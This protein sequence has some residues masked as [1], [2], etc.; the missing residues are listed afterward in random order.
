MHIWLKLGAQNIVFTTCGEH[1][2]QTTYSHTH[3]IFR[4]STHTHAP[5]HTHTH[6]HTHRRRSWLRVVQLIKI[7]KRYVDLFQKILKGKQERKNTE[8][9]EFLEEDLEVEEITHFRQL[10]RCGSELQH[11]AKKHRHSSKAFTFSGMDDAWEE[12]TSTI[13]STCTD[14][15]LYESLHADD[16]LASVRVGV[17]VSLT[18]L[19][20]E[21]ETVLVAGIDSASVSILA[22]SKYLQLGLAVKDI[23]ITDRITKVVFGFGAWCLVWCVVCLSFC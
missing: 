4:P 17:S 18:L 14:V 9:L 22:Q 23:V 6:T 20:S 10:A 13:N 2:L 16:Q 1:A 8:K 12:L 11:L 21:G 5:I 19:T 7:R 15:A 3:T